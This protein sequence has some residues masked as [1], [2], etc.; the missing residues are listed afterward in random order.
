MADNDSLSLL[1]YV[2]DE[3]KYHMRD[4]ETESLVNQRDAVLFN[5]KAMVEY[6][7][8]LHGVKKYSPAEDYEL[9]IADED[10][11]FANLA[12]SSPYYSNWNSNMDMQVYDKDNKKNIIS[13]NQPAQI[14]YTESQ[15]RTVIALADFIMT[16]EITQYAR[17]KID[18]RNEINKHKKT[19]N[20]VI[21]S[22]DTRKHDHRART[23]CCQ[24]V[25]CVSCVRVMGRMKLLKET[26][27]MW[28]T[29]LDMAQDIAVNNKRIRITGSGFDF[30]AMSIPPCIVCKDECANPYIGAS[31]EKGLSTY[32]TNTVKKNGK[33]TYHHR[34]AMFMNVLWA[35]MLFSAPVTG[36]KYNIYKRVVEY[37]YE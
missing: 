2:S 8:Q 37:V 15:S 22:T 5:V 24:A 13:P 9:P 11:F 17:K 23:P 7:D 36:E 31:L 10:D 32:T 6:L 18:T 30:S 1:S 27:K 34:E 14:V 26:R 35:E 28:I 33:G 4:I 21:C 20:C 3:I 25:V 12:H 19:K 29:P 16:G